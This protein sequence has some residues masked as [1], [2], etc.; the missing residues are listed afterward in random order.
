[1]DEAARELAFEELM[2]AEGSDW[3]WWYGPEHHSANDGD[4]DELYR[5]HLSNVYQALGAKPP[6]V[7]ALPIIAPQAA[8]T[9]ITPQTAFIRPRIAARSLRYF[10]WIGAAT[11]FAN[12]HS[13]AMHGKQFLLD[14]LYVGIDDSNLYVRIDFMGGHIPVNCRVVFSI[15]K[16]AESDAEPIPFRV[17]AEIEANRLGAFKISQSG[18][19]EEPA[20]NGAGPSS[21]GLLVNLT[22]ILQA[23]V[24]L[25]LLEAQTGD[26]LRLRCTV[27][28]DRV[29]LDSLPAEAPMEI[30]VATEESLRE[31]TD[32]VW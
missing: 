12:H 30:P 7:L 27:W 25:N 28:R 3:N 26:T 32:H 24:P 11:S 10:D 2:I 13:A 5:K 14:A 17:E 18:A 15:E 9:R 6:E 4:F 1:V 19:S 23:Q 31:L 22:G 16:I 21:P 20:A 29:P 8:K